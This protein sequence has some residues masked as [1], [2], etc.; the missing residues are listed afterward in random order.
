MRSSGFSMLTCV[1]DEDL[2]FAQ[3]DRDGTLA[4][5]RERNARLEK[6]LLTIREGM[7]ESV[8]LLYGVEPDSLGEVQY[9]ERYGE[10]DE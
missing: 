3:D 10:Y 5:L 8:G 1:S 2:Q 6:E 4:Y 7:R 9:S